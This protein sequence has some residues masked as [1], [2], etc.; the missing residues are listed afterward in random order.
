MAWVSCSRVGRRPVGNSLD[1]LVGAGEKRRWNIETER[2]G[3]RQIDNE[4]KVG[5]LLDWNVGWLSAAQNLVDE[6]GSAR[7]L[8]RKVW[9]IGHQTARFNVLP[10]AVHR[11]QS[12]AHRQNVDANP[13]RVQYRSGPLLWM[14]LPYMPQI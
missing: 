11:R 2:L 3:G 8:L 7:E 12:G 10:M 9:S 5:R 6:V 4:L 13:V 14:I 1:H